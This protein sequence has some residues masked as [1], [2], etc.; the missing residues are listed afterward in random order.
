MFDT[1]RFC[2]D[3]GVFAIDRS[4][5]DSCDRFASSYCR[6]HC[7]NHKYYVQYTKS[8]NGKDVK[9]EKAWAENSGD[10]WAAIFN[11][12]KRDTDRIR[13]MTRG[14]ALRTLDDISRVKDIAL[15]NPDRL[16]MLPTKAWTDTFMRLTIERELF[17]LDN[18]V[19]LASLDVSPETTT[20]HWESLSISG[21]STMFF[22]D[23]S[24]TET[25]TGESLFKCPKTWGHVK[26]ACAKCKNGCFKSLIKGEKVNVH[27]KQH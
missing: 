18:I 27:L 12:K 4:I 3:I 8:L 17:P 9:N 23:D 7:Y 14:E 21:W 16:F 19:V 2:A 5:P 24:A 1:S 25:P 11:R 26:G 15:A 6:E 13:L 20:L 22:G 10:D